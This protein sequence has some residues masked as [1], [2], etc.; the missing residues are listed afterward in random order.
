MGT[1][2][3]YTHAQAALLLGIDEKTLNDRLK[4]VPPDIKF[5]P[6]LHDRRVK[7]ISRTKVAKLESLHGQTLPDTDEILQTDS[8]HA[9]SLTALTLEVERLGQQIEEM[10]GIWGEEVKQFQNQLTRMQQTID[11]MHLRPAPLYTERETAFEVKRNTTPTPQKKPNPKN[12]A[13]TPNAGH[14]TIE[15]AYVPPG[16]I[17]PHYVPDDFPTGTISMRTFAA[18]HYTTRDTITGAIKRNEL[19]AE[20]KPYGNETGRIQYFF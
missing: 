15:P 10:I 4:K 7:V 9:K 2:T 17:K 14:R 18:Q 6:S 1:R 11:Q 20:S 5:Q 13:P 16:Q 12:I 3:Y 8:R 19:K